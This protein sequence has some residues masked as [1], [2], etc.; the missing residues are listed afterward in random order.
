MRLGLVLGLTLGPI[1]W[2]LQRTLPNTW[3]RVRVMVKVRVRVIIWPD[4]VDTA[5]NAP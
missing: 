4:C 3:V 2:T 5:E 1:G